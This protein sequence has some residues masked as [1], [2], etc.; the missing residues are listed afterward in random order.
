MEVVDT[1]SKSKRRR[2]PSQEQKF[3]SYLSFGFLATTCLAVFLFVY[4]AVLLFASPLLQQEAPT[5]DMQHMTRGQV[6]QPVVSQLGAKMKNLPHVVVPGAAAVGGALKQQIQNFRKKEGAVDGLPNAVPDIVAGALMQKL[7]NFRQKEGVTDSHLIDE[8]EK[9]LNQL[10]KERQESAAAEQRNEQAAAAAVMNQ[11]VVPAGKRTGFFVLGMHRSGTSMLSGLLVSGLGYNVGGPLIGSRFDNEKGFFE[12][13]DAVLQNDEFMNLQRIWWSF[14]VINY[15]DNK[16]LDDKKSGKARFAHGKRALAFLN[17]ADNVPWLQKDP[18]MCITIKTWLPLLKSEPAVVFTYR[19]PMEVANSLIKREASFT[20]DHGLRLWIVYN[21]RGI[22]NSA[23]LCRVFTS[24]DAV[25]ADP[26]NETKR[27]SEE[28]T[29]KCGVPAP[30]FELTEQKVSKFVDTSLQHNKKKLGEDLPVIAEHG[31][32]KVHEL[33]T[34]TEVGS[35]YYDL[36]KALYLTAMKL[37]CDMG[38]GAAYKDDYEW[39][40]LPK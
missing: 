31:D 24:N 25:L 22:Q 38:S 13:I 35:P 23:G 17:N 30:P 1:T 40:T 5:S 28:L 27:V 21:M 32:C 9:R 7:H 10:R 16:A 29:T 11:A 6:L 33:I 20:L 34:K 15:D 26:L 2:R 36:E 8:A 19:H 37:Y 4:A 39:P 18:R 3:S 14:N 12:L